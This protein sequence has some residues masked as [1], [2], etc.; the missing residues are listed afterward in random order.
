MNPIIF[1]IITSRNYSKIACFLSVILVCFLN[2]KPQYNTTLI[3]DLILLFFI[4]V[5][6]VFFYTIKYKKFKEEIKEKYEE[7]VMH[8]N[9]LVVSNIFMIITVLFFYYIVNF[10]FNKSDY[11]NDL[12]IFHSCLLLI[13]LF[14]NIFFNY[15]FFV[16][17]N[18]IYKINCA[19]NKENNND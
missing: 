5:F 1:K 18:F 16:V 4:N 8:T 12:L 11:Y 14:S 3:Y 7:L 15:R 6:F 19:K 13:T 17:Y 2:L 10:I 9:A